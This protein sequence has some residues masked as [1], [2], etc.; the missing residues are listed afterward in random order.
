MDELVFNC[1]RTSF[2]AFARF[3]ALERARSS[4]KPAIDPDTQETTYQSPY[5]EPPS[6]FSPQLTP[7]VAATRIL[8]PVTV[9]APALVLAPAPVFAPA[10]MPTS[11]SKSSPTRKSTR[12]MGKEVNYSGCF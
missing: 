12:N 8:A 11:V 10:T 5:A 9:L 4:I 3:C 7:L 2:R 1:N 6:P